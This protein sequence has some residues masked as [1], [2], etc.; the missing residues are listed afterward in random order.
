MTFE[1][2]QWLRDPQDYAVQQERYRHDQALNTYGEYAMFVLLWD[3]DDFVAG[4][5]QRCPECY[6]AYGKIAETYK[7]SARK[8]C[9]DC[10]GTTFEG[11]YKAKVIRPSMWDA[12]EE[13]EQEA[14]RGEVTIQ[15]ASIQS[16]SDFR[17]RVGDYIFR[18]DG[19]RWQMRTVSTSAVRTGFQ[20][21]ER[22]T[23]VGYNYGLVQRE[24]EG[25]VAYTIPPLTDAIGAILDVSRL[26]TPPDFSAHEEIRGPLLPSVLI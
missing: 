26:R 25:T 22:R 10:Y 11:G 14:R 9:P 5:V 16:T 24:E 17:L 23:E 2:P 1:Y 3:V 8:D 15:T 21:P 6:I 12:N 13:D 19:S 4:R 18:A 7:Q 20:S